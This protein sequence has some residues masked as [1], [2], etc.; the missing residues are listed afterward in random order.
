MFYYNKYVTISNES[1]ITEN[2]KLY[3]D[4]FLLKPDLKRDYKSS[5]IFQFEIGAFGKCIS[6]NLYWGFVERERT[7]RE[8][9]LYQNTQEFLKKL[10]EIR[11]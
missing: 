11:E 10:K 4:W 9:E 2:V 5:Y 6:M 1:Y 7:E 8:E 3:I